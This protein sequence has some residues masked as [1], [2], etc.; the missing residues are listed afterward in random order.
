MTAA[1]VC[2]SKPPECRHRAPPSAVPALPRPPLVCRGGC[3]E[4]L[5]R[6][7]LPGAH[8][9]SGG[10]LEDRDD[11][12]LARFQVKVANVSP[13]SAELGKSQGSL[14]KCSPFRSR[15]LAGR[16]QDTQPTLTVKGVCPRHTR[17]PLPSRSLLFLSVPVSQCPPP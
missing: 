15:L 4:D 10:S 12:Y 2:V 5:M 13:N 1:S 7:C 14:P 11:P 3:Y 9:T 6:E 17:C 8:G 16:A